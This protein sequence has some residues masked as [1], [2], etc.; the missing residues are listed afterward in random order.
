M[1]SQSFR[2]GEVGTGMAARP[3]QA[4]GVP[5]GNVVVIRGECE[6]LMNTDLNGKIQ[7]KL[8][9]NRKN[10]NT[11]KALLVLSLA[12]VIFTSTVLANPASALTEDVSGEVVQGL[13]NNSDAQA[14][15]E[16]ANAQGNEAAPS[17]DPQETLAAPSADQGVMNAN[18]VSAVDS[19]AVTENG[20]ED[21]GIA[22]SGAEADGTKKSADQI[23]AAE[24]TGTAEQG[25]T[26][27]EAAE[28]V[29]TEE[30]A[31]DKTTEKTEQ[32]AQ[33]ETD[34]LS[35]AD[36]RAQVK[37][38]R[39]DGTGFPSDT[40]MSGS[41]LGTDDWNRVLSAVSAKVKAQSDDSTAYSVA[42]LHT[43]TFSLQAGDGSAASYDDIRAE[44][45]FQG[46]LNDAGYATKTSEKEES[47]TD[48][49]STTTANYETSWRVYAISG[50]SIADPVEDHLTDLTDADGTS[51]SVDENGALQSAAFDGSLPETVV[52]AQI[53]RETVTTGT[54]KKKEIPMPAVTFDKEAATD[55]GTITVHVEADE[56]TFEQ[57][58]TMSVKQVS[59]QDILDKAIE[60]AGG[61]GSA[62]AVDISF[63]KADGTETE[64]AK[65]IRVKMTAK[66]LSQADKVHVVHVDDTGSTD[67]VA[68]KSDGKTIESTSSE[69]ASSDAKN[70]VSFESDSFSVYAIVYT[71][72]FKYSVN[73]KTYQFSLHGEEKIALSDLIEV[74]GII[75]DTNFKNVKAFLKEIDTV[76]FSDEDLLAVTKVTEETTFADIDAQVFDV[77]AAG[78]E[79]PEEDKAVVSAPDW[80]LTS[81]APFSSEETLVISMKN[82]DEITIDVTDDQ[83]TNLAEFITDASLEIEGKT[84]GQGQ[85]WNVREGVDY[86][87]KL[88]F[89]ES[90][91]RQFPQGG[92]EIVMNLKDLGGMSLEPGQSGTFDVP[93]GLYGT[94]TGNTWW[95][96][97]DGKLHIKFGPDPDN[98][99]T[100]SNNVYFNLE[101]DVKFS[102]SGDT[103]EF[104]DRVERD[105]TADTSS[106]ISIN[107]TGHYNSS[108]GKME[109]TVTVT[110]TGNNTNVKITD[111]FATSNLL[112]LDQGSITITP[113]K[114]LASNGNSTSASGFTRVISSMS[115]GETVTITYTADVNENALGAG[116]KVTGDDGK[117]NVTVKTDQGNEDE[118]TSIVNEIKWSD[119]SKVSTS[120]VE[121]SDDKI[122]LS[123]EIDAN[124]S[125]T[126]S[127][128]GSTISDKIDWNS[129]EYMKYVQS[130]DGKITLHVV[131]TAADGT[132]YTRDIQVP[133]GSNQNQESWSWVVENLGETEGTP[134]SYKITYD[135]VA[136]K[137]T[138]TTSVKNNAENSSGGSDS[139]VGV[140][141]GTNPGGGEPTIVTKKE[142]TAVTPDY[143]DWNIVINVPAEGFPNGLKV[144]DYIPRE[145]GSYDGAN[146]F[147]DRLVGEPTITGLQGTETFTWEVVDDYSMH[148]T[149]DGSDYATQTLTIEFYK[150]EA[151]T[152]KG[153][154]T[155]ARTITISLRT[156]NDQKWIDYAATRGGGD[157]AYFH[158]N[159]GK[160]NNTEISDY[161]I[162]LRPAIEKDRAS[163]TTDKADGNLPIYEYSITLSNVKELPVV[164]EDTFDT[165]F[166]KYNG[167]GNQYNKWQYI[168]AAEQKHN[169]NGGVEGYQIQVTETS[170]GII[171]TADNLPKK[172]NGSFYEY[173]RIYYRL[174]VK[175]AAA[176]AAL[177][178]QAIAN[179]GKYTLHNTAVWGDLSDDFDVDYEVTAVNKEGY[180]ASNNAEERKFTFVID[181]NPSRFKLGSDG[182][183]E[184]TDQHTDNLSVDYSSVKI[185]E[186]PAGVTVS[187]AKS[188][189][190]N[191]QITGWLLKSGEDVPWNFSGNE[192]TFYLKDETHYVIVYDAIVIGS[193]NQKFSNVADLNGFISSKEGEKT[194]SNDQSA[195][196][197]VWEIKLLKYKDGLTSHGLQG[198]TFQLFRGTGEYVPV[199]DNE[200]NTWWEEEKEPMKYGDT[201]TT[202][203]N[204]TVGANI[205]FTTGSDGTVNIQVD[206]VRDGNELEGGVHYFLKEIDSPSGYQIDSS[207]E[208]WAF[209]LTNDP[210]EVNYGDPNRR[211]EYG[212][213]Q[214][215]YFYYNDILKMA[216]TETQ[217][218][219]DVVVNKTW[220]D[221]NGNEITGENLDNSFVATVQLLRKTDDGDYVPV[222]VEYGTDGKPSSI[223][224]VSESTSD[225]QIQLTNENDWSYTWS[226]LPRVEMG[227]DKGLDVIH[228]Y[229]YKIEEVS[230]DGYVVSMS[231]SE[232]ETVKTYALKNYATPDN[233]T[234]KV[235]VNKNWQDSDGNE[236]EGTAEKLPAEIQFK[237]YRAVS[238]TPFTH[239]PSTGGSL[240]VISGDDRLVSKT[241]TEGADEYGVY[242]LTKADGWQTTFDDL[243][244]TETTDGTTYYYAYYVKEIPMSGYTT[245]YTSNGTTRT[246][247][248]REPL[249]EGKYI[250]IGLEKK[251][252][253]GTNT[254]PPSGASATFTVHQQKSTKSGADGSISVTAGEY[255]T[256]CNPGDTI[257]VSYTGAAN[258]GDNIVFNYDYQWCTADSEGNGTKSYIIPSNY[259]G[260]TMNI[261]VQNRNLTITSLSS[262]AEPSYSDF[263]PTDFTRTISLPTTA[264]TWST[265]IKDLIQEDAE[266]NLYRYYITED[267]CTPTAT[268][269]AF[270]DKEGND[271]KDTAAE[272]VNQTTASLNATGQK[273]EVT[274][275]YENEMGAVKVTKSFS[276]VDSLPTG[277]Q[278]ANDYNGTVFTVGSSGM[279]GTGTADD[280]YAWI[281]DNVPVGTEVTFTESGATVDG[282]ALTITANGTAVE[283]GS[284]TATAKAT[285]AKV[286]TGGEYP[287]AAFVNEYEQTTDFEF[288]K[289]WKN[290]GNQSTTWPTGATITV[291]MN[292]YTDTSQKAIDDVQVTLSAEGSVAGVTPA[293]SAT[294]NDDG[295]VTTFKVEGLQK[296]KDGKELHYYVTETQ[297]DGYKAPSYATSEG[298]GLV[299][300]DSDV[301]KAT[302]GHQIINTPEGGYELPSTGGPGTLPLAG[303]GVLL[304]LLAGT[305][306]TVRKLL[307]HRNPG[308][309][310][311]SE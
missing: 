127:L 264:G 266:G 217:E 226:Q 149:R 124:T 197:E 280:P 166:L 246:I 130:A 307:I 260:S 147:A 289:I 9:Q 252:T 281:L 105:W 253:D 24:G 2:A 19:A 54:E 220:Y 181:A 303:A 163:E 164:I 135:T 106:D 177:K 213:R 33:S 194:Y 93:L 81:L 223:T 153:L 203:A 165:E 119:L 10:R 1:A 139:G 161:G 174:Q 36:D 210:D 309:G 31:A 94:V 240:Y 113:D 310:G 65:P 268:T 292:A 12:A 39:K 279:T 67:V 114:E 286:E 95:V 115:H 243:P 234:T 101:M 154:G 225:S 175:D 146:G 77:F 287:T 79:E 34:V 206:Q 193:G 263:E 44:A 53:V 188:A 102:G 91:S 52:F 89:K 212:N 122:Q 169:L 88:T 160:V 15:D 137:Q 259:S 273:V 118:K 23:S 121:T 83:E 167:L 48:G 3:L 208:Y 170:D 8:N 45:E 37:I 172:D 185:Y 131:G 85:T 38:A 288:S 49:T 200:G 216:N 66:V 63:R 214:W 29:S 144:T 272:G 171:I 16:Q 204:G 202:R 230:V 5:V 176:L 133:V 143:I 92:E 192:G 97:N 69:A 25:A 140:V 108:T 182:T 271:I 74:L 35:F 13:E 199:S 276:G 141:P 152:Q 282:A 21:S 159:K 112:T 267:S 72:D 209:T 151:K 180:F 11:K 274:N 191:N 277:F 60:A 55:H 255:S 73:G 134:L 196:G 236:I 189:V 71:V 30:A 76:T 123:W 87:L 221:K 40:T 183:V 242:K 290:I 103:V 75:D 299:F 304:L 47:R 248:N 22:V 27:A 136:T 284:E 297:V 215:I 156:A 195:G 251:W 224:V 145:Q 64:P 7:G 26:L 98:L 61:K 107:K 28:T 116:G 207:T 59:S 302:N 43:W 190:Q 129:K 18:S 178:A 6:A 109:Y 41:P 50:D 110:S 305:A 84:Y 308:K 298:N 235:T 245:T 311:G 293:W 17:S 104:N 300:A 168:A 78:G 128:V 257:T 20:T 278:I 249:P 219:L 247:T 46:G 285:S 155:G 301:P 265:T 186:I 142:A 96:D 70:A 173:Y 296:Y 184:L 241:A 99:L 270:K 232:N 261:W 56:G 82:G 237:L 244:E 42:G 120:S 238:M 228:R 269:V 179:G 198:A 100:R 14:A 205:T 58:T 138:N 231:E 86:A 62:A 294:A 32:A 117:N 239:V 275:T 233:H 125:R 158:T 291:T 111:T 222:K 254:T 262:D 90:G 250:S 132:V 126:A 201:P 68:K 227:G 80:V 283:A 157:P 148:F 256:S 150:D 229:A 258:S 57:G 295:T 218:P 211:D 187:D 51:L 4:A 306:L 162:P